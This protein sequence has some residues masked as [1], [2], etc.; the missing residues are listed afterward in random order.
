MEFDTWEDAQVVEN[1]LN[2]PIYLWI[3]NELRVDA[4]LN[5]T[6]LNT[7]PLTPIEEV[8]TSEQLSYIQSQ[9]S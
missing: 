5:K 2:N 1:I 3:V 8:L 9:L 6:F 7:L 4:R